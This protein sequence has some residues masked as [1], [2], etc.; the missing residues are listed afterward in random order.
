[1]ETQS[2]YCEEGSKF[3][4]RQ[5]FILTTRLKKSVTLNRGLSFKFHVS[6]LKLDESY[7]T[8]GWYDKCWDVP[9]LESG[10]QN[11]LQKGNKQAA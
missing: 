3:V 6:H 2:F 7:V 1:M 8:D 4:S 9:I 11:A 10:V 5:L